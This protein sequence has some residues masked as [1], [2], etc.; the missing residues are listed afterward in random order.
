MALNMN[1]AEQNDRTAVFQHIFVPG[2][3]APENE[4]GVTM[5]VP[6]FPSHR[7]KNTN[8]TRR[9]RSNKAFIRK[10]NRKDDEDSDI[11]FDQ[12]M[13]RS[14]AEQDSTGAT[15]KISREKTKGNILQN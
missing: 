3:C 7:M 6:A 2:I 4:K 9:C 5:D 15:M 13:A 10:K 11:T 8:T 14:R 12:P 1:V